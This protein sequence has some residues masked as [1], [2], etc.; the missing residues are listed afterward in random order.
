MVKLNKGLE[1]GHQLGV[2]A[3][4]SQFKINTQEINK[5]TDMSWLMKFME[6]HGKA[7]HA[8]V[9]FGHITHQ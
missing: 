9:S 8:I 7:K 6:G 3:L 1:G 2:Y 5:D 4:T